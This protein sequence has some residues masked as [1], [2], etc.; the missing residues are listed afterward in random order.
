MSSDESSPKGNV[1]SRRGSLAVLSTSPKSG[2]KLLSSPLRKREPSVINAPP[3]RPEDVTPL[4]QH[5]QTLAF[6]DCCARGEPIDAALA[7][8]KAVTSRGTKIEVVTF[9]GTMI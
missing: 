5:P 7:L 4:A 2:G 8:L 3:L 6:L 1:L 9:A